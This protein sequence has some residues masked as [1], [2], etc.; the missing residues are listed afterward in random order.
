MGFK[1]N[2]GLLLYSKNSLIK[3]EIGDDH[4]PRQKSHPSQ[5]Y[6]DGKLRCLREFMGPLHGSSSG[7]RQHVNVTYQELDVIYSIRIF[8][9]K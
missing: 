8:V 9:S 4:I 5:K 1:N 2:N 6:P 3:F 7:L